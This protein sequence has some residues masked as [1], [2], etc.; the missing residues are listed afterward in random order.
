MHYSFI[1]IPSIFTTIGFF[2]VF[3]RSKHQTGK[4][5]YLNAFIAAIVCGL[6]SFLVWGVIA[7]MAIEC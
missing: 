7:F 2:M 4:V 3:F 1:L 6:L 5:D